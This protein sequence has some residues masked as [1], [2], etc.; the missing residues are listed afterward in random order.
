[1]TIREVTSDQYEQIC[2]LLGES[3]TFAEAAKSP[4]LTLAQKLAYQKQARDL[5][6]QAMN[7]GGKP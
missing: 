1:M 7:I 6:D 5:R 3:R 2:S 4:H